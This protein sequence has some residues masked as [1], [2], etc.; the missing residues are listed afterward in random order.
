MRILGILLVL[1][2]LTSAV[3]RESRCRDSEPQGSSIM[4]AGTEEPG[5]RMVVKGRV[6]GQDG[7]GIAGLTVHLYHTDKDGYYNRDEADDDPVRLCGTLR[8]ADDGSF[9]YETIRPGSYPGGGVPAH[10]H[11]EVR[12]EGVSQQS[13][14]LRF[15]DDPL[16]RRENGEVRPIRRDNEGIWRVEQTLVLAGE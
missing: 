15:A 12:G 4:I 13:F 2:S 6:T 16:N 11:Y 7:R 14:E 8:T 1:L 5:E 3:A 9:S 10:V